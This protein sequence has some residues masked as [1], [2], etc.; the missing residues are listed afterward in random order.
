MNILENLKNLL[1]PVTKHQAYPQQFLNPNNF[2]GLWK[3]IGRTENPLQ[4]FDGEDAIH[5]FSFNQ[6]QMQHQITQ[7]EKKIKHLLYLEPGNDAFFTGDKEERSCIIGLYDS[8]L[9]LVTQPDRQCYA[10]CL[11]AQGNKLWMLARENNPQAIAHLMNFAKQ[12]GY[13]VQPTKNEILIHW[14]LESFPQDGSGHILNI[15]KNDILRFKS[16]DHRLHTVA[17][18]KDDD[19]TPHSQPQISSP[20]SSL[21]FN[22]SLKIGEPGTYYLVCPV[23]TNHRIMRIRVNVNP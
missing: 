5:E 23:N 12:L 16:S 13:N 10:Y 2:Q 6:R 19:W 1:F 8:N 11:L 14:N 7:G 3:E 9:N 20:P 4:P 21:E 15:G 17:Q 18:A 22:K